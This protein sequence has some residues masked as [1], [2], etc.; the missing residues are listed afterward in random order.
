[1]AIGEMRSAAL[2]YAALGLPVFPCFPKDKKPATAHGFKDATTDLD[3]ITKWWVHNP[4][5][6]IGIACGTMSG[7][8]VVLDFDEDE[9]KGKHG[10]DIL[11]QWEREHGEFPETVRTITGRGGYHYLYYSREP[12]QSKAGIFD[13]VDIRANGGYIIAPPSVHPNGNRYE[14]EAGY[15][16]GEIDIAEIDDNV[17]R[18]ITESNYNKN[19]ATVQK[20]QIQMPGT[21]PEGRR[22]NTLISLI[23]SLRNKGLTDE[24]IRAA[25]EIENN[26]KCKPPLSDN[27]LKK[28]VFTAL[29]RDWPPQNK[30]LTTVKNGIIVPIDKKERSPILAV[31]AVE[32]VKMDIPPIKW[33]VND[34]LTIGIAI[35][36]APPKYYKSFLALQLCLMICYGSDFMGKKTTKT[37]C[38]YFDLESTKRRPR[39]RILK[40]IGDKAPPD[41]LYFI[42]S[43]DDPGTMEDGFIEVLE[44]QFKQHPDIGFVVID[45]FQK[46]RRKQ[47]RNQSIYDF[48]YEDISA[49]KKIADD[50]SAGILLIHHTRKMKDTQDDFNNM[51]GSSGL[52]GAADVCWMIRRESRDDTLSILKT[53]G[54]DIPSL[55]LTISFNNQ[56]FLWE[57]KGTAEEVKAQKEM[58]D[59]SK[60]PVIGTIKKLVTQNNG[61]WEGTVS[62]IISSSKYLGAVIYDDPAVVGKEI[63]R[64]EGLLLM[65]ARIKTDYGRSSTKD[66]NRKYVFYCP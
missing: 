26:M 25:V 40:M 53:T 15:G 56:S 1:M 43:D 12:Y 28:E 62:E 23:G 52:L 58:D 60:S 46:I 18:F 63:R 24:A 27:T 59:Y 44:D 6:N 61:R 33:L 21:I 17:R 2:N 35:L 55:E 16:L 41:G 36:A 64:F 50:H 39:D 11:R 49:L 42:T 31:N 3:T 22:V 38:L 65:E 37:G 51:S 19:N 4:D 10:Y 45:V 57:F 29:C 7:G 47:A 54:R 20:T 34:I 48:D 32:L 5:Y 13:D 66:R 9:E 30:H 14:F 8:L